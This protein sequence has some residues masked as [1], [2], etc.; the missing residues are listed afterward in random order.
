MKKL[1]AI[2]GLALAAAGFAAPS[3]SADLTKADK[4]ASHE[5]AKQKAK[6]DKEAEKQAKKDAKALTKQKKEQKKTAEK[7][8]K[9]AH[10]KPK[11]P[12]NAHAVPEIDG[13]HAA[14]AISLLAGIVAIRREQR[15]R[16]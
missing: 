15:R 1:I 12:P 10:K 2:L 5:V 16:R 3:Y 9:V 8:E 14:L 6:A 4:K 11:H 7:A 13:S